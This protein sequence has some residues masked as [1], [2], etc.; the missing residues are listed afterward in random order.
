VSSTAT[1]AAPATFYTP[2]EELHLVEHLAERLRGRFAG[3]GPDH[4]L[5]DKRYPS[6][7]LQLG[8]LPA[9]PQPDPTEPIGPEELAKKLGRAPSTMGLD[10][11]M[12]RENGTAAVEL[13]ADFSVYVQRYPTRDEQEEFYRGEDYQSGGE[14]E[15]DADD[16][17]GGNMRLRPMFDRYDVAVRDRRVPLDS[18]RGEA[19]L[20]LGPDVVAA[21]G[22]ALTATTTVYPLA[23]RRAQTLPGA[24]LDNDQPGF[25][26]AT[27]EAEGD[28]RQRPLTPH[29]VKL[30]VAWRPE[31]ENVRVQVTLRN[32]T[33]VKL[34]KRRRKPAA[35]GNGGSK[36]DKE[37]REL[38]RDMELFNCRVRVL[39]AA[40]SLRK[41]H[42][43]RKP[44]DYRYVEFGSV[45]C[46]GRNCVGRRMDVEEHPGEPLTTETWPRWVQP[47]L[48][49]KQ[50]RD[51][52]VTFAELADPTDCIP[53]LMCI[54]GAM[55]VFKGRWD[56]ALAAMPESGE[57][58]REEKKAC[59]D[60][61][62]DFEAE[63]AAFDR[64]IGCL[65][66]DPLLAKAFCAANRC[67]ENVGA[68]RDPAVTSWRLFQVVYIVIQLQALRAREQLTDDARHELDT[69]DVLWFPTGGGKS[70]A[71]FGLILVAMFY[72]RLRGKQ[73]GA[74]AMLRFPLRM[75]SVQQLQRMLIMVRA[76]EDHRQQLLA[77]GEDVGGDPFALGYWVGASNTPNSLTSPFPGNPSEHIDWWV[78]LAREKPDELDRR[79]II[80]VCPDLDCRGRV[81]LVPDRK[82]VRLRHVCTNCNVE[83]PVYVTDEE[84]YRYLP[85][86]L[87]CTVDKV[88]HVARAEQFVNVLAGPAYRCPDHGYFTWHT[89]GTERDRFNKPKVTDRCLGGELCKRPASDYQL[90]GPTKDPCPAV[91]VQ[92]ELHLLEEELGTFAAHY[93]TLLATLQ[94]ELGGGQAS[95]LLAA[96]AT[97]ES[98]DE[99]VR[100]L[101]ARNARVFPSPGWTLWE[102]FYQRTERETP[103]R[104]YVGA[105]PARADVTEFGAIAQGELH[106][107]IS[108]MQAD[109]GAAL[110]ELG[111]AGAHE[112]DWLQGLL[113][114]YELT[115]GY[116]NRK[117]DGDR[118]AYVL[119]RLHAADE[120]DDELRVQVLQG[121]GAGGGTTLA[122]LA[123]VIDE[124][125]NQYT[126]PV[127]SIAADRLRALV[128]TSI[129]SH[130]VDLDAL[131]LMV[132]NGMTPTVAMYVQSS[133]RSGRTHIGMVLTS[134]DRRSIRQR[135]FFTNFLTVHPF[136]DRMI[137]PVPVNRFARFAPTATMPGIMSALLIQVFA[138]RRLTGKENP[139]RPM[140]SMRVGTELRRWLR[141]AEP[142]TDKAAA[143]WELVQ[144]ALGAGARVHKRVSGDWVDE[145]VFPS[146][147]A[148]WLDAEARDE[149][150]KQWTNL[151]DPGRSGS[152]PRLFNPQ[153]LISFRNVDE[154]IAFEA[155]A[156]VRDIQGDLAA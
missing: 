150:D 128:A 130:G 92:D 66:A 58:E 136:L 149:F 147:V 51:T 116:V 33:Q 78:K 145:P 60:A 2:A 107:L 146:S 53:A 31:G 9:L 129:I 71:Y 119:R 148:Q 22:G 37:P 34:R 19:E 102:S 50:E 14:D 65:T 1:P 5:I 141:G 8:I 52:Q 67:F 134:F 135:A 39:P 72:D 138:R 47:R 154:P 110:D 23:A 7:V 27:H 40:G 94:R 76:A 118:V 42:Y 126:Q 48:F 140:M 127:S 83:V 121:G 125:Q 15:R 24:A 54:L 55:K 88:A 91:A 68:K 6:K 117:E 61:L 95:K 41:T 144:E 143:L 109:P 115:L 124:V 112:T 139:T 123:D 26:H 3:D 96:T 89:A 85:S 35:D 111:W 131:N 21:L 113:L 64:G 46:T 156:K 79:R 114:H 152:T 17:S 4:Q 44:T 142:P 56:R 93:E 74:T 151:Q 45:W 133:S 101:Y 108:R 75:L 81:A 153:P 16:S 155:M 80:T 104:L 98:F 122:E 87:V 82:A 100:Q 86:V 10:F 25:E 105:L 137:A 132:V 73:R 90:V 70:E 13:E 28:A 20:D 62:D 30:H 120:L 106:K 11:L 59:K 57:R 38:A 84:V 43:T 32:D 77:D 36:K 49:H 18:D 12:S 63:M 103:R 69:V 29:D 97:I 99:Q